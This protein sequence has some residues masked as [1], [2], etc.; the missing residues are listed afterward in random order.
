MYTICIH[1]CTVNVHVHVHVNIY[2]KYIHLPTMNFHGTFIIVHATPTCT[3]IYIH[4]SGFCNVF[5]ARKGV[6]GHG[7]VTPPKSGWIKEADIPY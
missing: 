1:V 4:V 7:Y 3:C 5:S 2:I 6:S